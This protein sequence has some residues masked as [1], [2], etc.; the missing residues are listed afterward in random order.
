MTPPGSCSSCQLPPF[1]Q[2]CRHTNNQTNPQV[3]AAAAVEYGE[4]RYIEIL[5]MSTVRDTET[6][7]P[8]KAV[9]A[10]QYMLQAR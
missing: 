9:A 1:L 10:D 5:R 8:H 4:H 2:G 3:D 7:V 6:L